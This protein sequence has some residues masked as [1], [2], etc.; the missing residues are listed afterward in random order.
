MLKHI[1]NCARSF[2]IF[3]IRI[4]FLDINVKNIKLYSEYV[5]DSYQDDKRKKKK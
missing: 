1:S 4:Y 5:N 2:V 3:W